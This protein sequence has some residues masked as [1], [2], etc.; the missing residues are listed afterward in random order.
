MEPRSIKVNYFLN[1]FRVGFGTLVGIFTMPYIN[2]V[3]GAEGFGKVEYV[4]SIISYFLLFSALGIPLYGIRETAKVRN[5][6]FKRT[7][8]ILEMLS[9]LAITTIIS[10]LFIFGVLIH[11]EY[12]K[13]LKVLIIVMSSMVLFSNI[14]VEWF[15][16][17]IEDQLF[18]TIRYTIVR[19]LT[20]VLLFLFVKSPSD[21]IYYGAIVVLTTVGSNFFNI[22]YL[23]KYLDFKEINLQQLE[24]RKHLKPIFTIFVATLSISIYLQLDNIMLGSLGGEKYVG[25]YAM[26]NKLIRFVI[27]FITTLG[28]VLLPRM[29]NLVNENHTLYLQYAKKALNYIMIVAIPSTVI[30][31]LFAEDYT[32]L[33]AGKDFVPAVTT[34]KI[35]SPIIL[36]VGIAYFM[37]YLILYPQGK[38]RVYTHAT[39]F[40]AVL[41]VVLNI[42][43]I[44]RYFQNGT[45]AVAVISEVLGIVVMYWFGRKQFS[46]VIFFGKSFFLYT[47]S[48]IFFGVILFIVEPF[49]QFESL[50]LKVLI[51]TILSFS[52]F[53][54]FLL[55][56][57]EEVT[58]EMLKLLKNRIIK[59]D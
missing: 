9:I 41:S 29:S 37:G 18:I 34:M 30:F 44:P 15:Y 19:V 52:L 17:G 12:F 51:E 48:T 7:K 57:K 25:Y 28:S 39:I 58:M 56:R 40:S 36:V 53:F 4:N 3:L 22:L 5:Q 23:K 35:L 50:L 24:I 1:L 31:F 26:A 38:E 54:L 43:V 13:D 8:L 6:P 14:G 42:F 16:Q 55:W 45:A 47:V 10:Y 46:E 20:L 33:M 21:Y 49:L 32:I 11:L 27:L 59:N 2:K